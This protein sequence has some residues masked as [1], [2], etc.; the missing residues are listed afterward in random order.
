MGELMAAAVSTA[1]ILIVFR[2]AAVGT[3]GAL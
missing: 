1:L 2:A 3:A